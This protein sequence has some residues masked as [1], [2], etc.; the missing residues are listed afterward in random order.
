LR[1]TCLSR[2]TTAQPLKLV[3]LTGSGLARLGADERLCA[4]DDHALCGR[5]ALALYH[6]PLRPDG[7]YFR[8]RHDPARF[9]LALF[10]RKAI[11]QSIQEQSQG[12]LADPANVALLAE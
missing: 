3:D 10:S 12:A 7:L 8:A 9:S 1:E 5:W 11:A 6:H 2:L 4:G